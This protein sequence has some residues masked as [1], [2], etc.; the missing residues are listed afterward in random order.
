MGVKTT[1]LP[2]LFDD[3]RKRSGLLLVE[4]GEGSG[5]K[6]IQKCDIKSVR[7]RHFCDII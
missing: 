7:L 3:W 6:D 1:Y 5:V 2:T 4:R